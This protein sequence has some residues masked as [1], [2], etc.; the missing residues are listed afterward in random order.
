MIAV[1]MPGKIGDSLYALP[2]ARLLYGM[3]GEKIDFYTSSYCNPMKNLVVYQSYINDFIIPADYTIERTDMGIQPWQ[4]PIPDKYTHVFQ[5]GFRGIPDRSIHQYMAHELGYDMPLAIR[6]EYPELETDISGD[7]IC[8]APRGQTSF[9]DTFNELAQNTQA[10]IIGGTGDYTG[11]GIDYT[12]LDMLDTLSVLSKSKGFV[13]LMSS[14][15]VLANG[16]D[17]PRIAIHDGIHW[18]MRHVIN[19]ALNHYPINPS[20]AHVKALLDIA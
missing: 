11:Y 7:Y 3:H 10:V 4:M 18:D 16:L 13:G 9:I 5:L 19:T 20:V 17:I 12:G 14:Q 8:I 6:Y 2:V 15:L 1:S